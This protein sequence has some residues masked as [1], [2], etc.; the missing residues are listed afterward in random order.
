[1]TWW[2]DSF[3]T[4]ATNIQISGFQELIPLPEDFMVLW[5]A[6]DLAPMAINPEVKV[7]EHKNKNEAEVEIVNKSRKGTWINNWL[8]T[9]ATPENPSRNQPENSIMERVAKG[10]IR[11]KLALSSRLWGRWRGRGIERCSSYDSRCL[12]RV[13][14]VKVW[15]NKVCDHVFV[16]C[17]NQSQKLRVANTHPE[18]GERTSKPVVLLLLD[19]SSEGNNIP[20]HHQEKQKSNMIPASSPSSHSHLL[21]L[22]R[23]SKWKALARRFSFLSDCL[24]VYCLAAAFP[25]FPTADRMLSLMCCASPT[26][27]YWS[28][29]WNIVKLSQSELEEMEIGI[30][31]ENEDQIEKRT[32]KKHTWRRRMTDCRSV[33]LF[34]NLC[35]SSPSFLLSFIWMLCSVFSRT[36]SA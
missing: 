31:I 7:K 6:N 15:W 9:T 19:Q 23:I 8:Q 3:T 5:P 30:E 24:S 17:W 13:L 20:T 33:L 22:G 10:G 2:H 32:T 28:H 4:N 21:F 16:V 12:S 11:P 26:C 27:Y 14:L 25:S 29:R 34:N 1:M 36:T 35:T 18:S